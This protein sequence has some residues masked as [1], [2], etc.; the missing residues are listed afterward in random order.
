[1]LWADP[2][3][4]SRQHFLQEREIYMS[5]PNE[6]SGIMP[7]AA[8]RPDQIILQ[9]D[10][11]STAAVRS[12]ALAA[13][14]GR[15]EAVIAQGD[16][17][18]GQDPSDVSRI[19]LG[20]GMTVEKA[21]QILSHL[22]G[23]KFAEPDFA[24]TTSSVSNDPGVA[25]GGTW[26]LYGDMGASVNAFGSQATEAWAEGYT[27]SSKVAVGV[28]DTGVDYTHADLYLNIWLNQGEIPV[29][30]R[31]A[32]TDTNG[33]GRITFVDLNASANS[34]FVADKNANGRID[35]G[36]LLNDSRWE[37]GADE[38]ANGYKD[39]LIG[40]D[41]KNNDNDP[42]DD[43]G[44][45]THVAGTI[46]AS[47]AN[48]VG[49]AGVAWSTQIVALKFMDGAGGYTSDAV[50]AADYF[51]NAAKAAPLMTFAATNNS[52]GGGG[53]SQAMLDSIARGAGQDIL[54]VAAAM[55][56]ASNNDSVANWP[57][58]YS[59]QAASGYDAVVS[60]AS[61]ASDGT[62]SYFSNYGAGSVDLAAPGSDIYSTTLGGGYGYMSG[63]S[64]ATPHVAGSIALYAAA[65]PDA[66]A[67]EIRAALLGSTTAT[68]SLAGRT[69]TGGRLDTEH[70]VNTVVQLEPVAGPAPAPPP[71]AP[72]PPTT[73]NVLAGGTSG[74]DLI[75]PTSSVAGQPRPGAGADTLQGLAGNDTLDGGAG[76]DR[77]DG[78]AGNDLFYVDNVADQAVETLAGAAGGVDKV[79]SSVSFTLDAN[80]E[81]LTLSGSA[82]LSGSGN[83][84]ANLL[85][86]NSGDNRLYGLAGADTLNGGSGGDTLAG[87]QGADRLIGGAGNDRFVFEKGQVQGDAIEDFKRGDLIELHGYSAQSVLTKV[88][89]SVW[90]V[91]DHDTGATETF[92]LLNNAK[93]GAG[94]FLFT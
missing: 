85:T 13:I 33:D 61:I 48:G 79:Q 56:N 41:F 59:T 1:L 69:A 60:V 8:Y 25:A 38:D 40:W 63:T 16:D 10:A 9:F 81:N 76:A 12:Q 55:N 44:H 46:G 42:M 89:A 24:V 72:P 83:D 82:G 50:R 57:S 45:G 39:D 66:T 78:G 67:A 65:H 71:P 21:I 77:L 93:L 4:F 6:A 29:A 92:S 19:Q 31:S 15:L 53:F 86:G 18:L 87:G 37:N 20:Q 75:T 47:G 88:S 27:G 7:A 32:L 23:V 84:L 62:L 34:A 51:T 22:P 43:L 14:G 2:V 49:V 70:F 28:I 3:E 52:W 73:P 64:M 68:A 26:G 5:G 36:D 17:A 94:D 58:N 74:N 54:F 90:M 11:G 35:A 91:T 30:L 80:V